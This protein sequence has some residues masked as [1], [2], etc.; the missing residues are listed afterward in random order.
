MKLRIAKKIHC[1]EDVEIPRYFRVY[2][3]NTRHKAQLRMCKYWSKNPS[4][5]NDDPWLT[6]PLTEQE[7]AA[8]K[9]AFDTMNQDAVAESQE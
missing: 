6:Q 7:E 1:I 8:L 9:D 3:G 5:I 4:F 2:K